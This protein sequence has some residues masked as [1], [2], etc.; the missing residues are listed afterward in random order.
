M[1]ECVCVCALRIIK[2]SKLVCSSA[3]TRN[4]SIEV[5][6]LIEKFYAWVDFLEWIL[7]FYGNSDVRLMS[8]RIWCNLINKQINQMRHFLHLHQRRK[9]TQLSNYT[10]CHVSCCR[11]L[12]RLFSSSN[13][14]HEFHNFWARIWNEFCDQYYIQWFTV[15]GCEWVSVCLFDFFS[16]ID[17]KAEEEKVV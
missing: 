9:V 11:H 6:F 4:Q 15:C 1:K 16:L 5:K 7:S 8:I 13:W 2:P 17:L 10:V 3:D 12:R 14:W